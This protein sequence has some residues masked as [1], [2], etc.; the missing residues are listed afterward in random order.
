MCNEQKAETG[1]K[2]IGILIE[3]NSLTTLAWRLSCPS[4]LSLDIAYAH[5]SLYI[6]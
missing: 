3:A 2:H 6:Q 4:C 5:K 1:Q